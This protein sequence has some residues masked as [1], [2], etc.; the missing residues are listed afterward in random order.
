MIILKTPEQVDEMAASGRNLIRCLQMLAAKARPG[1]TLEGARRSGREVHPLAGRRAHLKG[2]RG[3]PSS[4][5]AS[6]NSM[7]VHRIPGSYD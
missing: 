3:F 6:R 7:V 4:I 5:C 2:Y 1:D